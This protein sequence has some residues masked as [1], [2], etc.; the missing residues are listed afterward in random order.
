M[1][2][3]IVNIT[4]TA[5]A[6]LLI[7]CTGNVESDEMTAGGSPEGTLL[8]ANQIVYDVVIKNHDPEDLW[9][10]ECLSGLKRQELVDFI[11]SGI[12]AGRFGVYDIFSGKAIPPRKIMKM[13]EDGIFKRD[14][15][16]KIQFVEEW[17]V[18]PELYSMTKKVSEVRLGIEH[19]DGFGV[20]LGHNPLFRVRL[21]PE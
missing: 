4:P 10:E 19:I 18:D 13:E 6:L 21:V 2:E 15:I 11:F 9:T 17:Y 16:S 12:Y 3:N 1:R 7:S 14:Q 5:L 20:H 8:V